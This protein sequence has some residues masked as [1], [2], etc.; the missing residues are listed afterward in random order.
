MVMHLVWCSATKQKRK[1]KPPIRNTGFYKAAE[2]KYCW[3][4]QNGTRES[5]LW[6]IPKSIAEKYAQDRGLLFTEVTCSSFCA[7]EWQ[8]KHKSKVTNQFGPTRIVTENFASADTCSRLSVGRVVVVR[9]T[10]DSLITREL[11]KKFP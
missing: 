11:T 7:I 10:A 9:E 5:Y 1:Q 6:A 8:E 2:T 4:V 3:K